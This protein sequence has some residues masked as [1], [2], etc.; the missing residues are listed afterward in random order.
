MLQALQA[1]LKIDNKTLLHDVSLS[2]Q[3]GE[4]IAVVGPNGAGKSTL[5][6]LLTGEL[7]PSS[8][9]ILMDHRS[10]SLCSL[11]DRAMQR[12]VLPQDSLLNFPFLALEV[13]LIGR[14]PHGHGESKKDYEI[15]YCAL[16]IAEV[17]QLAERLYT[18][19]SGGERQ[20]VQLARVL[21]QIWEPLQD[22]RPRYL[23]LDEPTSNLDL[24]HQ[25]ATLRIARDFSR[26]GV[27]VLAV[28]HDLNLAAQYADRIVILKSGRVL[29]EGKPPDVLQPELID[30]AFMMPVMVVPHP[31]QDCPLV[32]AIPNHS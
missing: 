4:V 6:K 22:G 23:L 11:Q 26:Q 17:N 10:L 32:V 15:A 19:L 16:E 14:S 3:T 18:T 13:V 20:R 27:G 24:S 29:A 9:C 5:I 1:G 31:V 12:A 7:K 28:L 30:D 2:L 25:H 21:S 8:G